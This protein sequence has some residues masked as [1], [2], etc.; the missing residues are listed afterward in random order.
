MN[1]FFSG[2]YPEWLISGSPMVEKQNLSPLL[3]TI[4][5]S[6]VQ[7]HLFFLKRRDDEINRISGNGCCKHRKDPLERG[8]LIADG[9]KIFKD[10]R[11]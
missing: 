2:E 5:L 6:D 10:R 8:S 11:I 1:R 3:S 7:H 9:Q 4:L